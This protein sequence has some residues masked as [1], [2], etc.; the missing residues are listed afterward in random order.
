MPLQKAET[1]KSWDGNGK[2]YERTEIDIAGIHKKKKK[3]R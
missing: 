1:C 3:K 2:C